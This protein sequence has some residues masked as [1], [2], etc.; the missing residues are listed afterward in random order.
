MNEFNVFNIINGTD[1]KALRNAFTSLKDNYTEEKASSYCEFYQEKPLSFILENSRYIF[2][3]PTYG[4]PFYEAIINQEEI[5]FFCFESEC[6]KL[7]DF[8]YEFGMQMHPEQKARFENLV[9]V[10]ENRADTYHTEIMLESLLLSKGEPKDSITDYYD[11]LYVYKKGPDDEKGKSIAM[12][13]KSINGMSPLSKILHVSKSANDIGISLLDTTKDAYD[14]NVNDLKSFASNMESVLFM[15][16][17]K[18]SEPFTESMKHFKNANTYMEMVKLCT[19]DIS[20]IL[21]TESTNIKTNQILPVLDGSDAVNAMFES[22]AVSDFT[23]ELEEE[24]IFGFLQKK[25]AAYEACLELMTEEYN[26]CKN[27]EDVL[28]E[29]SL[30]TYVKESNG[31]TGPMTIED[32]Y[33]LMIEAVATVE[34]YMREYE[35]NGAPSRVVQR[36]TGGIRDK[37]TNPKKDGIDDDGES[38]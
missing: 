1:T 30:F 20:D 11:S 2:A 21:I 12:V 24:E 17:L 15:N 7:K 5:P 25:H 3:E 37:V 34:M 23:K 4:L 14:A 6:E 26:T 36:S 33:H 31:Y 16:R 35:A 19:G 32:G 8:L 9:S 10:L 13:N 22:S 28:P 18:Y 38:G 27:T 29:T